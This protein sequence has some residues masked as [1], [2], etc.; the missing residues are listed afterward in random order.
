MKRKAAMKP[1]S[2]L[3]QQI[4]SMADQ[5]R[6]LTEAEKEY[7]KAMFPKEA[8]YYSRRGNHCEFYCMCCGHISP[9]LGKWPYDDFNKDTWTCPECG[10]ECKVLPQYSGGFSRNMNPRTGARSVSPTSSRYVV[11]LDRHM[12]YQV[13]RTFEVYRWNG[14]R[15]KEEGCPT[16]FFFHEIYQSWISME[17]KE[18]IAS[19]SYHRSFNYHN[20]D[21]RSPWCI[22]S[23]NGHC[24]GYYQMS[25]VYDNAGV[26][27]FPKQSIAPILRRNGLNARVIRSLAPHIDIST[28]AIK[29]LTDNIYEELVKTGQF[30][31]V[32]F[33]LGWSTRGRKLQD[34]LR[35]VR[36]CTRH[37]YKISDAGLWFDYIDDLQ[38]LGIDTNSPHY[39]CPKNLVKAHEQTQRRRERLE[40]K[41]QAIKDIEI[42]KK[43]EAA[44]KKQKKRFFGIVFGD[45]TVTI[46]VLTSVDEIRLEGAAMHHCVFR[47]RYYEDKDSVILSARDKK[48]NRLETVEIGL[49]PLKVLQSRG[50][51]NL[52]T[53][54][55]NHIVSL[56][57]QHLGDFKRP[58]RV[59]I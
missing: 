4:V 43:A 29:L 39:L 35:Q 47:N 48:G 27:F 1:R 55:H 14:R 12:G 56:C 38:Y 21:Y 30:G 46:R 17:G 54:E 15:S 44:Y 13:F 34:F 42:A 16:E 11:L 57:E 2:K 58:A 50:L 49:N 51:Q 5:L 40:N 8:L 20:W 53:P 7:A 10:A 36:I 52:P 3:Q 41:R 33:F 24:S 6:S 59:G 28:L 23:H 18:I 22:G 25:D 19:R 32:R 37:G 31:I 9:E 45:K 26:P